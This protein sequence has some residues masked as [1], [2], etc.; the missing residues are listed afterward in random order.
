MASSFGHPGFK[1]K[2]NN[3]QLQIKYHQQWKKAQTNRIKMMCN[4]F[5]YQFNQVP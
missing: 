5:S 3:S 1:K 2:K 4:I